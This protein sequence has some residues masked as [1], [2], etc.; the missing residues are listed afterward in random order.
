MTERHVLPYGEWPSPLTADSAAAGSRATS[1]PSGVGEETWWCANDPATA[2]VRLL[3][4]GPGH[5]PEPVLATGVSVRNRSLGYGGRPYAVRPGQ[6]GAPH[7]LVFTDHRDQR[8]YAAG[9]A[10]LGAGGAGDLTP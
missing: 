1:W 6:D 5:A 7:L 8:L 4:T 9:T 10:P 2:T 3:R